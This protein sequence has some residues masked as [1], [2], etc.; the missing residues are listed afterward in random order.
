MS[1]IE[2]PLGSGPPLYTFSSSLNHVHSLSPGIDISRPDAHSGE[3]LKIYSVAE[4][5][6]Q[7]LHAV[8]PLF[9]NITAFRP[10]G[11][12]AAMGLRKTVW[13]FCTMTAIPKEAG[14]RTD[15]QASSSGEA[16]GDFLVTLG[17][18]GIGR[19]R[20]LLRFSDGKWAT[21]NDEVIAL[22]REGSPECEGMPVLSVIKELDQM[23]LDFLIAAWC[24]TLWGELHKRTRHHRK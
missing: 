21:E 23:T 4:R 24:V 7:P 22:A 6:I 20:D 11:L 3:S 13:D 5:F 19:L 9:R 14:G 18:D 10:T 17:G 15:P 16:M 8:P 12:A 2:L 1:I